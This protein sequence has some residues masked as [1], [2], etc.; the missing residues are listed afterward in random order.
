[1]QPTVHVML[2]GR[3][4]VGLA[5]LGR[6]EGAPGDDAAVHPVLERR[7]GEPAW[8]VVQRSCN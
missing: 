3:D 8:G 5:S 6:V 1:M 4:L 2:A 7:A